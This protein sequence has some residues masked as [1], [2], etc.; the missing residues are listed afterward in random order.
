M[1]VLLVDDD[2]ILRQVLRRRISARV[3][4]DVTI[5]EAAGVAAAR[6]FLD[7]RSYDVIISDERMP[8]GFGHSLL[9]L[10]AERQPASR[11]ALMSGTEPPPLSPDTFERFF[12]KADEIDAL[13]AWVKEA[14][15]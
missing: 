12:S 8:D 9:A 13:M 10:A 4:P 1:R 15:R 3:A 14:T 6:A 7:T 11:R 2:S 5:D